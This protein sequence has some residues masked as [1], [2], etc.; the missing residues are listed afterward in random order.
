MKTV[1]LGASNLGFA[2][3]RALLAAGKEIA[4]IYTLPA[5]FSIKYAGEKRREVRNVLHADMG[6]LGAKFGVPVT[7]VRGRLADHQAEL[8][9]LDPDFILAIG[10]YHMIPGSI[11]AL[12]PMGVAGIHAS[13]LPKY[14]GN[15]PLVWAMIEGE[16]E[17]G[18]SLFYIGEEVDAGDLIGQRRFAI[19]PEETIADVL[20]KATEASIDVLLQQFDAIADGTVRP[21]PQDHSKATLYPA[22]CPADGE[23]DWSWPAARIHNFIRAQTKPYPGAFTWLG[24]K[25][26]TIWEA[27]IDDGE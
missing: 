25:K 26:V 9:N 17:S 27:S 8:K 6:D 11:L 24:G 14:R 19:G 22:R 18:I 16:S 3:C 20:E 23:I 21:V 4:H 10:W 15:A 7:E 2:C 12:P 13:L 1:F 5:R